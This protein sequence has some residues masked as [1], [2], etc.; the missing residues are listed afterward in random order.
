MKLD[1]FVIAAFA[2]K[3]FS[4]PDD[5]CNQLVMKTTYLKPLF[6]FQMANDY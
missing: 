1:Y 4:L 6:L 5:S 2:D 3:L